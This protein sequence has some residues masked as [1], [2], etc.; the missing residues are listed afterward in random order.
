MKESAT[1]GERIAQETIGEIDEM[2]GGMGEE[3]E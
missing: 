1:D 2:L 3:G